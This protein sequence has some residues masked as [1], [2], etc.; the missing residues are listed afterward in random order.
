MKLSRIYTN[1]P[2]LFL[3]ITFNSGLNVVHAKVRL[4]EDSTKD[5]HNLGKTLLIHLIDFLLLKQLEKGHFIYDQSNKKDLFRQFVFFLELEIR[6]GAYVT[7]RRE[8][9]QSTK[10]CL[11]THKKPHQDYSATDVKQWPMS[12]LP[13]GKAV[14]ELDKLLDLRDIAP[15]HYRKGIGYFLRAQGDYQDVFQLARFAVGRQKAWM[16]FMAKLLG[17]NHELMQKKYEIDDVIDATRTLRERSR[18]ITSVD[19]DAYDRIKGELEIKKRALARARGQIDR[20]DFHK[21]ELRYNAELVEEIEV[22]I[23]DLND[24]LYT[25]NYEIGKIQKAIKTKI[26]FDIDAVRRIFQEANVVFPEQLARSYEELLDF[27][28]RLSTDR[29]EKLKEHRQSLVA[30]RREITEK[31]RER[32]ARR[33]EILGVLHE[34]DSLEKYRSLQKQLVRHEREVVRLEGVLEQLDRVAMLDTQIR[35]LSEKRDA[36]SEKIGA[37]IREGTPLY[38]EIRAEFSR[39]VEEVLG[40]SAII[41][42]S[43]SQ[44]GNP[45]FETNVLRDRQGE[46]TTSEDRGTS[47]QKLLCCAFDMALLWGHRNGQFYR[48]VYHDGVFEAFDDRKK[49]GLLRVIRDLCDKA[50]MQYILTV[51]EADMPRNEEDH[52]IPFQPDEVIL[53]LDDASDKGRLFR[54]PKF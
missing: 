53:Q 7:I 16:P 30:E 3:P 50:G 17:F 5:S 12:Y 31:L 20:F 48:F 44:Q 27:N 8:V 10:I 36:L 4:P 41:S 38:R 9:E 6:P 45:R 47:Y 14:N 1:K 39:I 52:V 18:D 29:G 37:L 26:E 54:M 35:Q 51:I 25:I 22:A 43:Q 21:E 13:L 34:T 42:V 2:G 15:F 23:S 33:E 11:R 28:R 32:S 24:R 49:R 46:E 40:V 19:M